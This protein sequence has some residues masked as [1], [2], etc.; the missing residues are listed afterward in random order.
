[1]P[2]SVKFIVVVYKTISDAY[3]PYNLVVITYHRRFFMK[4][5]VI[6]PRVL[7]VNFLV[8]NDNALPMFFI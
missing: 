8:V 5:A 3:F 7:V 6:I 2:V 4:P 1:L